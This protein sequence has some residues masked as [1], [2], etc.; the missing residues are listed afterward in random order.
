[1]RSR[2]CDVSGCEKEAVSVTGLS[3]SNP[4]S[5]FLIFRTDDFDDHKVTA[6]LCK[7]HTDLAYKALLELLKNE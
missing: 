7:E 3:H 5:L 4:S 6:Y 1:M 2:T